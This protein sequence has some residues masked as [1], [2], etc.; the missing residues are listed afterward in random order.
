M[1][2][3]GTLVSPCF[4]GNIVFWNLGLGYLLMHFRTRKY[5][6]CNANNIIWD[7]FSLHEKLKI[8]YH[9][10]SFAGSL[11]LAAV[12]VKFSSGFILP[13]ICFR[14]KSTVSSAYQD[15]YDSWLLVVYT[16]IW[17]WT[18]VLVLLMGKFERIGLNCLTCRHWMYF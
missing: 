14:K 4:S 18:L 16:K 15:D 2:L 10:P 12:T 5:G 8:S 7:A 11:T 17:G 6:N 9:T 13:F 3:N 1:A